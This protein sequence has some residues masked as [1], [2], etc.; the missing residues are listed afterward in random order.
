MAPVWVAPP[1]FLESHRCHAAPCKSQHIM[2]ILALRAQSNA[3]LTL[4][5]V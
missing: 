5:H 1:G 2:Y 4:L 3:D